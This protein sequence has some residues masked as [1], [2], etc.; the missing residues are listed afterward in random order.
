MEQIELRD[1]DFDLLE[2]QQFSSPDPPVQRLDWADQQDAPE[3][4]TANTDLLDPNEGEG[5]EG[6]PVTEVVIQRPPNF[7]I[8]H[9]ESPPRLTATDLP[10]GHTPR[11]KQEVTTEQ[12]GAAFGAPESSTVKQEEAQPSDPVLPFDSIGE[13]DYGDDEEELGEQEEASAPAEGAAS[14]GALKQQRKSKSKANLVNQFVGVESGVV[15]GA[16]KKESFKRHF[17]QVGLPQAQWW[18]RD[19]AATCC[20]G[21]SCHLRDIYLIVRC[22]IS[23]PSFDT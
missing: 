5:V 3:G 22:L 10:A 14:A 1:L 17:H 12:V 23:H 11:V 18:L 2:Q 15:Q 20:D 4:E 9:G 21:Q 13:V 6:A 7:N 8:F 19:Y 16:R